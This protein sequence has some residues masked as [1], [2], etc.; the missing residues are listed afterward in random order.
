[1]LLLISLNT[2]MPFAA[3]TR[4]FNV[5]NA[6]LTKVPF[7]LERW[8]AAARRDYPNGLPRPYSDDPTQWIFHGHPC[9]SVIWDDAAK[10][11]AH[12]P[13]RAWMQLSFTSPSLV[14]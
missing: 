10:R 12:A 4:S 11:T 7:D 14:C 8:T 1:M 13:P 6:T 3:S 9:G 5:T 2:T